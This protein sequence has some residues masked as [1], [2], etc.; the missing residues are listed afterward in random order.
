MGEPTI[1]TTKKSRHVTA[2]YG[3]V[4][5]VDLRGSHAPHHTG[6]QVPSPS[7]TD[8]ERMRNVASHRPHLGENGEQGNDQERRETDHVAAIAQ[9]EESRGQS[10]SV[11]FREL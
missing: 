4:H 6:T 5:H 9:S 2:T 7:L 1:E 3:H 8:E 10:D 11:E